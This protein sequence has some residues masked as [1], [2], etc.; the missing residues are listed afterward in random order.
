MS[1]VF[2]GLCGVT[3]PFVDL[4]D[5]AVYDTVVLVAQYDVKCLYPL[6]LAVGSYGSQ[7]G[8]SG[9]NVARSGRDDTARICIYF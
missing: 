5:V 2:T 3:R 7:S 4:F 6:G 8:Q 9:R 1:P